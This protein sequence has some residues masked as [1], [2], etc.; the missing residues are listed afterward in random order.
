MARIG[1][2]SGGA[3]GKLATILETGSHGLELAESHPCDT[4]GVC[5]RSYL[6][7]LCGRDVWA[8]SRHLHLPPSSFAIAW[9]EEEPSVDGFRLER[10][11]PLFSL[12]LDKR[13][14]ARDRSP[15]VFLIRLPGGR[16]RCGIYEHR[17]VSC[18][19]YPMLLVEQ[20][21]RLRDDPLC[22]P[23]A[24]PADEPDRP[25]WREA[26]DS[27]HREF[28]VYQVV[29]SVWNQRVRAGDE[30]YELDDYYAY[31]LDAYDRVVDLPL[32]EVRAAL[33]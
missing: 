31:L 13:S 19:A 2:P 27:A 8:I 18:R 22:P 1:K 23:G 25:G 26:L 6:V 17:P 33:Y 12:V 16:D 32:D 4:C 21:V 20:A 30:S 15:C 11:G 5:C 29:V 24:W 9:Q 28:D 7:P 14:W 10:D 3:T